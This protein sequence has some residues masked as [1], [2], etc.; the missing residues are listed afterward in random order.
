MAHV[1]I[2]GQSA[3]GPL[4][5]LVDGA[6]ISRHILRRG[7]GLRQVGEN[8]S[9]QWVISMLVVA[10]E[11]DVDLPEAVFEPAPSECSACAAQANFDEVAK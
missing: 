2:T 11:L 8:E 9:T 10:D 3:H 6:D 7:F 4:T 1:K 5:V